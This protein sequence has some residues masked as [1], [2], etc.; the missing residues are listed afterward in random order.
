M[1]GSLEKELQFPGNKKLQFMGA[2]YGFLD[3]DS[4]TTSVFKGG[5]RTYQL[6]PNQDPNKIKAD[7]NIQSFRPAKRFKIG[8]GI[9]ASAF[10]LKE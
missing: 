8:S 9:L 7:R 3:L 5:R 10:I 6:K 2:T 4:I 1:S